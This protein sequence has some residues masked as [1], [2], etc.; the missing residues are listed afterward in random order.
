MGRKKNEKSNLPDGVK[1]ITHRS[2]NLG[3]EIINIS[4]A[5]KDK[6]RFVEISNTKEGL[7]YPP[8]IVPL[9]LMSYFLTNLNKILNYFDKHEIQQPDKVQTIYHCGFKSPEKRS[10]Q[11]KA[12][13]CM[14]TA[15]LHITYLFVD[16]S[17]ELFLPSNCLKRFIDVFR[18]LK[19]K[20]ICLDAFEDQ[21]LQLSGYLK[22]LWK[23]FYTYNPSY[24]P[25]FTKS[26]NM[27]Y[28][29]NGRSDY[30][31][32][33]IN[34][35]VKPFSEPIMCG[36][37]SYSV[38]IVE[39]RGVYV[40]ITEKDENDDNKYSILLPLTKVDIFLDLMKLVRSHSNVLECESSYIQ[41]SLI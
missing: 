13:V 3:Q 26:V 14:D 40:R 6:S 23:Y 37:K 29:Y 19:T 39:K 8:I 33:P 11:F 18:E 32:E 21:N 34:V 38:S 15:V 24:N 12:L 1:R 10:Y 5:Q 30:Q 2:L 28:G 20:N 31:K 16:M 7:I 36:E 9:C 4:L 35:L 25:T 17:S 41:S 22:D 27:L